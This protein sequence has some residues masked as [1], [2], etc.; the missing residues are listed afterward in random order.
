M[1]SGFDTAFGEIT[2]VLFTTLAP[3]GVV[4]FI[5]MGLPLLRS[6]LDEKA[7]T[8]INVFL[9]IPLVTSMVG[10]VASATHLGNPANALYVFLGVGRSPLSTEVFCAVVFLAVAGLY[11]LYQFVQHPRVGVQRAWMVLAMVAGVVFVTAIAFAYHVETIVSWNS[12]YVPLALWLNALMA[13]PLLALFGLRVACGE[14][15]CGARMRA[16]VVVSAMAFAAG[17]VVY[18]LQ[19]AGLSQVGNAFLTAADLVPCYG[20]MVVAYAVLGLVAVGIDAVAVFG[21]GAL[22]PVRTGVAVALVLV[23]IFIMRFVFYM[24]HMTVGLGV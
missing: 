11:W 12:A 4:A 14:L 9:S 20:F 17:F 21:R 13:G 10:L 6:N 23:G 8:R 16:Y 18:T 19:G 2:L 1:V 5:L 15:V 24:M 7:R 3:A 22:T